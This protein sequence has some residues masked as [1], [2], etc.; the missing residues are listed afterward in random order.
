MLYTI[1]C[2]GTYFTHVQNCNV[3][4]VQSAIHNRLPRYIL[5]TCPNLYCNSCSKCYT[6]SAASVH[7]LHM[8]KTVMLLVF[9]VPCAID[10]LGTYFT[11]VQN[12]NVARVQSAMQSTASVHTLHMSKTVMLLVFKVLYTI[13]CL[14][15]YFTHVQ[16][17]N[18]ARVQSAMQSTASVHTLHMSKPVL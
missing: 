17:C 1:D 9:K 7:T 2:L 6:Q 10:C 15:T 16:N 13:D 11:H 14:G 18:V 12:C 4:R 8:S 5:Y 3:A